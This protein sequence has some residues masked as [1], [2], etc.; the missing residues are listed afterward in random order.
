M[1]HYFFTFHEGIKV[2]LKVELD[3]NMIKIILVYLWLITFFKNRECT[4]F[5]VIKKEGPDFTGISWLHIVVIKKVLISCDKDV[6]RA[7]NST[8]NIT[9]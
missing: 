6:M 2:Q 7:I 4:R 8:V 3:A 5:I 1:T 9:V